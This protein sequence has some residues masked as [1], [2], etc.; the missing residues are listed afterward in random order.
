VNS[1][2]VWVF[3]KSFCS[4]PR[5]SIRL[6]STNNNQPKVIYWSNR[7]RGEQ[8]RL[9]LHELG[10]PFDNVEI[11]LSRE[12]TVAVQH[13]ARCPFGDLPWYE[14]G[15]FSLGEGSAIMSYLAK[16]HRIY[17]ADIQEGAVA[18]S[19]VIAVD[20][21]RSHMYQI[22]RSKPEGA[23]GDDPRIREHGQKYI[24]NLW[25]KKWEL[26]LEY[27][28]KQNQS[29]FRDSNFFVGASLTH[30]DIAV[31][32]VMDYHLYLFGEIGFKLTT[33]GLIQFY[34]HMSKRPNLVKY[35]KERPDTRL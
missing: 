16:K 27:L 8:I 19:I 3:M 4:L 29:R 6:F 33:P 15:N 10:V 17:P 11:K 34:A 20:D 2:F 23:V 35:L 25:T 13:F 14:D 21:Y 30:A 5:L 22:P 26:K 1:G 18:D 12:M 24:E 32:D 28:L 7:G 9:L 31:F